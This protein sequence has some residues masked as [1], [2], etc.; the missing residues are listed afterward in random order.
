MTDLDRFLAAR[1]FRWKHRTDLQATSR[2][3][4]PQL[5]RFNLQTAVDRLLS[6]G[7]PCEC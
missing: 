6:A 3:E 7:T 4:W 1:D 5:S 2:F